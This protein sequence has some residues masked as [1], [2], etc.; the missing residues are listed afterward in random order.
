MDSNDV[1]KII[2]DFGIDIC[3]I[4]S[5]DKFTKSPVGFNPLDTLPTCKS[6]IIFGKKFLKSTIDC[7][8]KTPYTIVR[9]MISIMLDT[10]AVNFCEILE[11]K[12]FTAVPIG[13]VGPSVYDE[14]TNRYHGIVSLKHSAVLAGMGYIGKNSLLITPEFGNMVWLNGVLT[15]IELEADNIITDKCPD[16][17]FLCIKNCPVNA[18]KEDSP[19]MDQLKCV[20]HAFEGNEI[21]FVK[22]KC[23]TCRTICPKCKGRKDK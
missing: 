15:N 23:H 19:E 9:N 4:A 3:G 7:N 1:K 20:N 8:N 17:C 11:E 14:K 5:I 13:A 18:I 2:S 21:Y 22:I 6:V 16:N 10:I 12:G